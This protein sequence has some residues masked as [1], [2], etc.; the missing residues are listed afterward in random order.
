MIIL[1]LYIYLYNFGNIW[2]SSNLHC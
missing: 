2:M 1:L